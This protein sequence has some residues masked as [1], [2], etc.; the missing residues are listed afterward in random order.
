MSDTWGTCFL[1]HYERYLGKPSARD[2]FAMDTQEHSIQ[3][4]HFESV[5][6]GCK[7]YS[8]MGFSHF[9]ARIQGSHDEVITAVDAGFGSIPRLL[10]LTLYFLAEY[11]IPLSAGLS[12]GGLSEIDSAFSQQYGKDAIYFTN[13]FPL[14]PAFRVVQCGSDTGLTHL[15]VFLSQQEHQYLRS[16]GADRFEQQMEDAGVDPFSLGRPSIV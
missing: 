4:L 1:D 10:A 7:V 15:A 6:P 2:V 14:P 9:A 12:K 5:F 11:E 13:P 8:T 3:V 16:H